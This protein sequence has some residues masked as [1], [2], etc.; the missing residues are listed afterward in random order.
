[1]MLAAPR[2]GSA[3]ELRPGDADE[4]LIK[5]QTS[6]LPSEVSF[7]AGGLTAQTAGK[8]VTVMADME[9]ISHG[10]LVWEMQLDEARPGAG[11]AIGVA[12]LSVFYPSVQNLGV[13]DGSWCWSKTGQASTGGTTGFSDYAETY[14]HGST[15]GLELDMDAGTLRFTKDGR[16][17]GIAC[18]W[19]LRGRVLTPGIVMGT[20][21]GGKKTRVTIM[22]SSYHSGT[23]GRSARIPFG[24]V[25]HFNS[26]TTPAAVMLSNSCRTAVMTG[27]WT[28]LLVH[29]GEVDADI[30]VMIVRVDEAKPGAGLGVGLADLDT[31]DYRTHILGVS[32]GSY[33]YSKTGQS[34]AS[35]G[36][37]TDYAARF[38]TGDVICMVL[39]RREGTVRFYKNNED[40]GVAF[41]GLSERRLAP[42][43]VMGS[44]VGGKTT[45]VTLM[46]SRDLLP[47]AVLRLSKKERPTLLM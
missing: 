11:L 40:Q 21:K 30:T 28:S 38:T 37:F 39:D 19:G 43:L 18:C 4:T 31:F 24:F 16:D 15:V 29:P 27:T 44:S 2:H 20:N 23:A 47:P 34:S 12:D 45:K 14:T 42:A 9:G 5:F 46:S 33:C 17:Q 1:M 25:S 41:E 8:W 22:R 6:G 26:R 13:G 36:G 7:E 35:A 32:P 10:R 3:R